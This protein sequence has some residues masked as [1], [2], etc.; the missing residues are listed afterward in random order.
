MIPPDVAS[1][2][3]LV[4]P[5]Q[6]TPTQPVAPAGKL[7][8]V[9]AD[10]VPGQRVLA[11]IQALIPNGAYRATIAQRD[12]VLALPFSAK[13]GDTLEL[14]VVE[15][16]GKLTLA[17]LAN[18][19]PAEATGKE[20]G[21][22]TTT[23]SQTGKLIGNL[24]GGVDDDGKGSQPA[25]LNANRPLFD[26]FPRQG[27]ELIPVLKE[28]ITNSGMFYEAHQ[29]RWAEGKL[30]TETL[31]QEPQGKLSVM[32]QARESGPETLGGNSP[33]PRTDP[34]SP[35]PPSGQESGKTSPSQNSIPPDLAPLVRQQLDA[36]STQNYVWQ[37]Q[38]WPGQS[39]RWEIEEDREQRREDGEPAGLQWQTR[40]K[41]VLPTLG[42]VDAI[43]R[44]RPGGAVDLSLSTNSDES[45]QKLSAAGEALRQKLQ[46]AGL[47]LVGLT[48]R[49]EQAEE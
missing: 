11:Q 36:L 41:L 31:L 47:S 26:N 14:E 40:L 18:R 1:R 25:A 6:P 37:G 2:L 28:A 4:T 15:S 10:L 27:A 12:I 8:D 29:A 7:A 32:A 23:L 19:S 13:P 9:L 45:R 24:L 17:F 21:S 5:D 43:L 34:N 38:I 39:M 49:H 3:R 22:V 44:L 30:P 48:V 42:G 16:D 46:D 35:P 20:G 33:P